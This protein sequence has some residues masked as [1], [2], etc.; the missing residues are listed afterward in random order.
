MS[1][2]CKKW[3][4][5]CKKNSV[6]GHLLCSPYFFSSLAVTHA[7]DKQSQVGLLFVCS[8]SSNLVG[9][10]FPCRST[11]RMAALCSAVLVNTKYHLQKCEQRHRVNATPPWEAF[12]FL[13]ASFITKYGIKQKVDVKRSTVSREFPTY[14][15]T[16]GAG[17]SHESQYRVGE[18]V[19]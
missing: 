13:S 9:A 10:A 5:N 12:D 6:G 14:I 16:Q 7:V 17:E 11:A 15:Q 18:D 19:N 2:K 8:E 4:S 3:D 1:Q